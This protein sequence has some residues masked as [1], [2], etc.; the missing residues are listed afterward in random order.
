MVLP[1]QTRDADGNEIVRSIAVKEFPAAIIDSECFHCGKSGEREYI[2]FKQAVSANFTDWN[3]VGQHICPVCAKLLSVYPY[4]YVFDISGEITLLNIRQIK[5]A[6]LTPRTG[7]FKLCIST[8]QKKHLFYRAPW[9]LSDCDQLNVQLELETIRSSRSRL[10]NLF[11]FVELLLAAGCTKKDLE[12]GN[13]AF[14]VFKR[15][16]RGAYT[17]LLDELSRSRDIRIPLFCAQKP[18]ISKEDAIRDL[19]LLCR[20]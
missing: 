14:D 6:L 13:I 19:Q 1:Y 15:V 16:G 20:E 2:A 10:G 18:D 12:Q 5:E 17:H 8:S 7:K 11:A 3:M 4:S 9:N